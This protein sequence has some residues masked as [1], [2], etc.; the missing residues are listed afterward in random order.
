M[1]YSNLFG[2]TS[3][4]QPADADSVNAKLLT[5]GGF[6]S[7]QMAGVYNYLP[8]G[9][10]VLNKIQ[11][12]I[13]EE[14]NAV[15]GNEVLMPTLT[16][17]E[18]YV[19]TGRNT[20]DIFF[21]TEGEGGTKLIL[22]PTHEEVV[23]P[24]VQ[25][26]TFS[27]RDLPVSVYQIQNKFR[28]EPRAKSGLL[29]GREF[30]M[31][32]MYSFHASKEDLDSYYEKVTAAY[33]KVYERLGLGDITVLTYASGGMFSKY[34]HEF[35]TLSDIGE[36]TVYLCEKC[37]IAINKEIINDQNVCPECGNSDLVERK[38]IEVGNIFKL[39]TKY[40]GAFDFKY[41]DAEGKDQAV[42]MGCYGM[43]P[44]RI[45]GTLV[46]IF[47]DE[48]GMVWPEAVAPYKYHLV[49]LG[50]DKEVL[51]A[52]EKLYEDLVKAGAEVLYDDRQA[53][54]GEKLADADLIGIPTR[55][56]VSKKT[57]EKNSVEVKKRSEKE[58][59]ILPFSSLLS[60]V[61]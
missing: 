41:T 6:I 2:K 22:N 48:K 42:E 10:R 24:L 58:S 3:K 37:K 59:S 25:K 44:S 18:S 28:N 34:S 57:V 53:T 27:Y 21:R 40:S 47:N 1:R 8:L 50:Q 49:V 51:E 36:D 39:G 17:E 14:M 38:G 9:L 7:K 15:D 30:N 4:S 33:R 31:K 13:R 35:Q 29:R 56:V 11:N 45:M 23:T 5:Q 52:A 20:M 12:I 16:Q 26:Y 54:A 55:L 19:T 61:K 60:S 46:E 32:D 43:G